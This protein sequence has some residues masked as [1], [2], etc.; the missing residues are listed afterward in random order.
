MAKL[1]KIL[2][3]SFVGSQP[4]S[5]AELH[6]QIQS[7]C[8]PSATFEDVQKSLAELADDNFIMSAQKDDGTD[9]YWR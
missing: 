4:E 7:E 8:E 1:A 6:K 2:I 3:L 9:I 5:A